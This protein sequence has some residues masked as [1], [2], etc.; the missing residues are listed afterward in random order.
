MKHGFIYVY[1]Y[2]SEWAFKIN[3]MAGYVYML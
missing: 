2:D 1:G 3:L